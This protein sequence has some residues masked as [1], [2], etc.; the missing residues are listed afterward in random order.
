MELHIALVFLVL[1][2]LQSFL[3]SPAKHFDQ[4][5]LFYLQLKTDYNTHT[6][7]GV[8]TGPGTTAPPV[9][10][11]NNTFSTFNK[12]DYEDTKFTH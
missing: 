2:Y 6:H 9:M 5:F 12:S 11:H 7:T 8:T 4:F 1:R 3:I 10:P